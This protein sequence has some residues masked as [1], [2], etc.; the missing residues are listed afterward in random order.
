MSSVIRGRNINHKTVKTIVE[1][2]ELLTVYY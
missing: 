1:M 2:T